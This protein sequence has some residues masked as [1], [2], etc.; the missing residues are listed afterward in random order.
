MRHAGRRDHLL[1]QQHGD[2]LADIDNAPTNTKQGNEVTGTT[3][4]IAFTTPNASPDVLN[5]GH[6]HG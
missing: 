5:A 3:A 6:R 1:Q 4:T 2:T